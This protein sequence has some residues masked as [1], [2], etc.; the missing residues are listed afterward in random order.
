MATFNE[1]NI[2]GIDDNRPPRVRKE[3]YIDLFYQLSEDAP[4]EWCDDFVSFGRHVSPIAKI[5][6]GSRCFISTYVNDMDIIPEHFEQIKQAVVECNRHYLEKIT[7]R[8]IDLT[9]ANA[10]SEAEGSHQSRLNQIIAGLD[11]GG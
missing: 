9:Q 6:K 8:E 11:F 3:A 2:V 4:E 10:A 1:I 5:E 7:Q